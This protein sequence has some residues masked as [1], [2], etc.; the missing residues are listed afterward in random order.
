MKDSNQQKHKLTFIDLFAGL[1]GFNFALSELGFECVFASELREDLRTLYT[2]N[3]PGIE[4]KGDITQIDPM[5]VPAHDILCA[6]FPCQP[7]SQAG[8]RQGFEDEK[9]RGN[10]FFWIVKI[11]NAKKPKYIILENVANLEN[12]DEGNTW[13][14]ISEELDNAGYW[15]D[16]RILS[17]HQFGIPQHRKR[18]Y[19]IGIDKKKG[20][21]EDLRFPEPTNRPCDIRT[22]ISIKDKEITPIKTETR[23]QLRIWEEFLRRTYENDGVLPSFP[24]WAMEFGANY[25]FEELAPAYQSLEQLQ[26]KRGNMGRLIDGETLE[27]CLEELPVYALTDKTKTF[28]KWKIS[29]IKQ[30]REFYERNKEW[31]DVWLQQ[32]QDYENSHLKIEWNCGAD[33]EPSLYD[34]IIQ[35]RAS[36]IRIKLPTYSPALNLVGTQIPIFPW[37]PLSDEP[38]E[39]GQILYGRYM[40]VKEAAKLQGMRKLKTGNKRKRFQMSNA[41]LYEA[42][43]NAVNVDIV[44]KIAEAFIK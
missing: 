7:F 3:F 38:D 40:T 18:I 11:L 17:P 12:H 30:N 28:P 5:S 2:I 37:V 29:Y 10:L 32:V 24:I 14:R 36:G 13:D 44:K 33:T 42:L 22:I 4:I 25:D 8:K 19:I 27:E 26:G 1:G 6:G 16:K 34:K 35:Y 43:G 15:I 20:S 21:R 23:E 31:L 9:D 39:N 41:R